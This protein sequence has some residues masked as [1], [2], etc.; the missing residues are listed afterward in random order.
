M[1]PA[2][3]NPFLDFSRVSPAKCSPPQL[4]EWK[5]NA[6]GSGENPKFIGRHSAANLG[7]EPNI[8][9]LSQRHT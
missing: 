5:R 7:G 3:L 6:I 8:M 2:V 1:R 9:I 4:G